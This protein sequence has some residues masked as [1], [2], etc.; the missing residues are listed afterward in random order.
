MGTRYGRTLNIDTFEFLDDDAAI[1]AQAV[2]MRI[3]TQP[4]I[5]F[6]DPLYGLPVEDLLGESY[7]AGKG[8]RL[9]ARIA[10]EVSEDDRI[11]GATATV[12]AAG[13]FVIAVEPD[14][15][16]TFDLTGSIDSIR[17]ALDRSD[18]EEAA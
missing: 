3:S 2:E 1:L 9:G 10:A 17:Q 13:K 8:A 11:L 6:K 4:G 12:D 5:Y 15:G 14:D 16:T 18:A 7:D